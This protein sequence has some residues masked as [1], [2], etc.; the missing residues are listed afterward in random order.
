MDWELSFSG[1]G[2]IFL[3]MLMLW[4]CWLVR[5]HLAL[6]KS[7]ESMS[8]AEDMKIRQQVRLF[9]ESHRR[10]DKDKMQVADERG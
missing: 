6:M 2:I 10:A 4:A 1:V 8:D 9:M 3:D 5:R 7:E